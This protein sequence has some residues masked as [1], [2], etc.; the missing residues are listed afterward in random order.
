MGQEEFAQHY[1]H[2]GWVE[3]DAD[4]IWTTVGRTIRTALERARIGAADLAG[5]GITNQRETVVVWDRATGE[6]IHRAIVWQDRRTADATRA[7]RDA[8]HEAMVTERTGLL[9]DPY[10]SA[11]KIAWMLDEVG[12]AARGPRRASWPSARSISWLIHRLTGG[13]RHVTDAPMPAARC[14]STSAGR[15]GTTICAPCSTCRAP[16]CRRSWTARRTSAPGPSTVPTCPSW[17]WR[18]TSTRP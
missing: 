2:P 5:I 1:P 17:A 9:L 13:A 16:C 11:S 4:E 8:G 18:A 7:L 15:T 3:H 12:G 6:P 10:F 14:C